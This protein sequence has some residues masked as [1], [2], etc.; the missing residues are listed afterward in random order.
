MGLNLNPD[1]H[2]QHAE[3]SIMNEKSIVISYVQT[4]VR[5]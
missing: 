3:M 5:A 1:R 4:S 2:E